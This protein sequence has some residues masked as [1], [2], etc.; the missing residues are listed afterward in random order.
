[1][2]P[3]QLELATLAR[4]HGTVLEIGAGTGANFDDLPRDIHWIGLEPDGGSLPKLRRNAREFDDTSRVIKGIAENIP[5][6]DSSVDTVLSTFVLCSVDDP[7]QALREVQRVLKP[8]GQFVFLEHV[9]APRGSFTRWLQRMLR[10]RR[11]SGECD[12]VRDTLD[13]VRAAGFESVEHE[14][15]SVRQ[16]LVFGVPHIAGVAVRG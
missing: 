11:R 5:L 8:G 7:T 14:P 16:L 3:E 1:M 6:D 13:I 9:A 12:P 15:Y 2:T 10:G 4:V